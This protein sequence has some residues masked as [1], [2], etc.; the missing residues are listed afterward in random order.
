M[1]R[2]AI[3]ISSNLWVRLQIFFVFVL[4]SMVQML[5]SVIVEV[6]YGR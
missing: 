5:G 4:R 3:L 6:V 1:Q 2:L